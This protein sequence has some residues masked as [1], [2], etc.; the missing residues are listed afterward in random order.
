MGSIDEFSETN[1]Y[2]KQQLEIDLRNQWKKWVIIYGA[3]TPLAFLFACVAPMAFDGCPPC[4]TGLYVAVYNCMSVGP[5]MIISLFVSGI[6]YKTKHYETAL[7]LF[8]LPSI[9]L[10]IFL[11]SFFLDW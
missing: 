2:A 10:L 5:T 4:P 9:N 8:L 3:L 1:D 11:A 6:F 7:Y